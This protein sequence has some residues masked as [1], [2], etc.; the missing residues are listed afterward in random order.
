MLSKDYS[1]MISDVSNFCRFNREIGI[2]DKYTLFNIKEKRK[3]FSSNWDCWKDE[4]NIKLISL[5]F[6]FVV[7]YFSISIFHLHDRLFS[8][9][10]KLLLILHI[11]SQPIKLV[12]INNGY[13]WLLHLLTS[14][15]WFWKMI[16]KIAIWSNGNRDENG[17]ISSARVFKL[18]FIKVLGEIAG[19][20]N[21][22]RERNS[23]MSLKYIATENLQSRGC[24]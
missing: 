6:S 15:I 7:F 5:C 9:L 21:T 22:F 19:I 2:S 10:L 20:P 23:N 14:K 12:L 3:D 1:F 8:C 24:F 18:T 16:Y 4:W 17:T 13:L 11:Y